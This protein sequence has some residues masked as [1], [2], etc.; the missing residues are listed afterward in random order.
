MLC[1]GL[2]QMDV[3]N[4][5]PT[6]KSVYF[7]CMLVQQFEEKQRVLRMARFEKCAAKGR[8]VCTVRDFSNGGI[9]VELI[10]MILLFV[11]E[12]RLFIL[13]MVCRTWRAIISSWRMRGRRNVRLRT[14]M[15]I[16]L[17]TVRLA[18][19]AYA[20]HMQLTAYTSK[21]AASGGHL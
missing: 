9:P 2:E 6:P 17:S 16:V 21:V 20:N 19:W 3:P 8:C 14:P 11:G 10:E 13:S 4:N 1:S 18:E 12:E 7:K 15:R 5:Q